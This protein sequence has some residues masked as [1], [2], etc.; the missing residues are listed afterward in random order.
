MRRR[1]RGGEKIKTSNIIL[2][3]LAAFLL[4][5][6][7]VMIILFIKFQ[8]V[9]DTLI[10]S[11]FGFFGCGEAGCLAM[12]KAMKIIKGENKDDESGIV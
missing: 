12:I 3:F 4:V 7:I 8:S 6:T 11:V 2:I 5:F 1:H 9:P 10:T